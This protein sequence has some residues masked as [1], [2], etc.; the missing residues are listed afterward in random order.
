LL[1]GLAANG[2]RL[3]LVADGPR[4]TF[5]NVLGQHQ[6]WP[7]FEA[8]ITSGDI[9]ELKPSPLMF[10][11][12]MDDLGLSADHTAKVVMVGNNLERDIA[13][14]NAFGLIS[15][16]F[17]WSDRRRRIPDSE[18][19]TPDHRINSLRELPALL[20]SIESAMQAKATKS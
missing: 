1:G 5:E 17:D 2:Y 12:A 11:A 19:E 9:G 6:L 3:A 20:D 16:F 18:L 7:Y 8:H 15:I 10:Q 4:K 13:G 14:A